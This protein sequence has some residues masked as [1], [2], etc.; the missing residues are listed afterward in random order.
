MWAAGEPRG[1]QYMNVNWIG[2]RNNQ[3]RI[4]GR[5]SASI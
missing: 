3:G 2:P 5:K 1:S 4:G